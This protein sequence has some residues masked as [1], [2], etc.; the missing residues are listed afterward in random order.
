MIRNSNAFLSNGGK[1]NP[2]FEFPWVNDA[3]AESQQ[4]YQ[5]GYQILDLNP[6]HDERLSCEI[7]LLVTVW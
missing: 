3:F 6:K 2:E 4:K 1:I 5:L 7:L